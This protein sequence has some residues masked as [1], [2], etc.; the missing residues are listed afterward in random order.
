[1]RLAIGLLL[2]FGGFLVTSLWLAGGADPRELV[3][4]FAPARVQTATVP[5]QANSISSG[6]AAMTM[7]LSGM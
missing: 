7:A 3:T 6:W 5:A 2:A 1:M 4:R